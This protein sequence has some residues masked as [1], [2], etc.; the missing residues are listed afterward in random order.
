MS[1]SSALKNFFPDLIK[2][3][4]SINFEPNVSAAQLRTEVKNKLISAKVIDDASVGFILMN[5]G[6]KSD[7]SVGWVCNLKA[8]NRHFGD[9]ASFPTELSGKKYNGPAL[10]I[11]GKQSPYIP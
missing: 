8:F 1:T 9:I 7:K 2:A 4:Q 6:T 10:F 3:M 5:L 11:G